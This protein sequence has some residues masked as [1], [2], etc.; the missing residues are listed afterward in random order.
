MEVVA[1]TV[2]FNC[3]IVNIAFHR[4]LK[5]I[6]EDRAYSMLVGCTSVLQAEWHHS[7]TVYPQWRSEWRMLFVI[8]VYLDLVVPWKAIHKRHPFEAAC[9]VNHNV[10]D[11]QRKFILR[12]SYIKLIKV[13]VIFPFFLRTGT[14]LATRSGCCSSRMKPYL[15]SL[16]TSVSIASMMSD[17]NCRC[18]CLIV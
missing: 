12:T 16:W 5:M 9:V 2:A 4:L 10:N 8:R 13:D 3:N 14:M 17:R 6:T 11:G 15:M 7:I 1:L 18:Y